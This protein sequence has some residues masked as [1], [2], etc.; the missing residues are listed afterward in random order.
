[1]PASAADFTAETLQAHDI[2]GNRVIA[3]VA[4]H[5]AMEPSADD[6][7]GFV[8]PPAGRSETASFRLAG[9]SVCPYRGCRVNPTFVEVRNVITDEA[10]QVLFV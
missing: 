8:P 10:P 2:G 1:M 7:H 5:H 6:R 3:E 4:F 9:D